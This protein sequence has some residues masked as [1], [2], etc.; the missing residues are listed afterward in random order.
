MTRRPSL[1]EPTVPDS[2]AAPSTP[3][4]PVGRRLKRIGVAVLLLATAASPWWG[5]PVLAHMAFFRVRRV[6]IEGARY[7]AP[8]DIL[9][10]LHV[11]TTVSV[12]T[13]LG[14][15][16]ARVAKLPE[17]RAAVIRRKLPGTLVVTVTERVPVAVV[18]TPQGLR[19]YDASGL[20]LP[21]DPSRKPVDVPIL[22]RR[23]TTALRLLAELRER[24]PELYQRVSDVRRVGHEFDLT[25]ATF[26]VRAMTD[27]TVRR[28]EDVEPVERDLAAR[29]LQVSELDLRFR[30]Q[31]IARL[32]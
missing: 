31:V 10:Q 26:L 29:R 6:R 14:P 4:R 27:V 30:D 8:R 9:R 15:L 20:P 13:D 7:T 1:A 12:W 17:V 23:D 16:E 19:P 11:D 3:S 28:L 2:G 5:P 24:A 22:A 18:P 25:F 32:K 21:I